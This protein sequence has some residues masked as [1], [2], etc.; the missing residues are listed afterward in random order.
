MPQPLPIFLASD[1]QLDCSA[2]EAEAK[3][4]NERITTLAVE[5]NWK[6]GQ[7][8]AAGIV[9]FMMWP[10]WLALD[11]QDAAGKE[12]KAL[13]LRNE[14]LLTLAEERCQPAMQTASVTPSAPTSPEK[15]AVTSND[16]IASSLVSR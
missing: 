6:L 7:N 2:I 9:G 10:A 16:E 12:A 14:Y 11:F 13:S 15:S 1:Q 4:N 5:Q 3:L 8:M